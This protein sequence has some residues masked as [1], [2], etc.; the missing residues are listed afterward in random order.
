MKKLFP[1]QL[2]IEQQDDDE[3]EEP[4]ASP[5]SQADLSI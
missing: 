4:A 3:E 5:P 1:N 2:D